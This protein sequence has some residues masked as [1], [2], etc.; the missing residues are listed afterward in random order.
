M[1]ISTYGTGFLLNKKLKPTSVVIRVSMSPPLDG[2]EKVVESMPYLA[3]ADIREWQGYD[4]D[5]CNW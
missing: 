1:I 3:D 2:L 4:D 5:P